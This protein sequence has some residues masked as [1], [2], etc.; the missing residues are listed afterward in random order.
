MK[1]TFFWSYPLAFRNL[2]RATTI[3][4]AVA[5]TTT[6]AKVRSSFVG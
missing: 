5:L 3:F 1:L 2:N 6:V 4:I